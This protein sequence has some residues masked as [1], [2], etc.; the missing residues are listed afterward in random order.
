MIGLVYGTRPEYIK[1]TPL[2]KELNLLEVEYL[3][4]QVCQH[5]TLIDSCSYD[6]TIP[7]KPLTSN[8]L[9]DIVASVG[10]YSFPPEV[11]HL[12]VQ[13][14]TTTA[15][16]AALNAF[17]N[18]IP[19]IHLEAGLRTDD[20]ANPYPEEI[21]RRLISTIATVHYC[22]TELNKINL[23]REGYIRDDILVTGNT[24]IDNIKDLKVSRT[25]E[26][27]VTLHRREKW[28]EM[29]SWY[30]IIDRLAQDWPSYSFVF[31]MHPSPEV[32]R[33][34]DFLKHVKV[35]EP[36]DYTEMQQRLASCALVIT[37]SGGIQEECS[38]LKKWCMVCRKKTERPCR[39]GVIC[40]HPHALLANFPR[41]INRS[42]RELKDNTI[43]GDG[44][45]GK[46][47][48]EDLL[49]RV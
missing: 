46:R 1:L 23:I 44:N 34:K 41:Y 8:R 36:L 38:F 18:N 45:A 32:R 19:V 13:G 6:H 22:P 48:V 15:M 33:H 24:G 43:F 3:L 30:K 47:I 27:I 31:P 2:L 49:R 16:A 42:D 5:T 25:N 28:E 29:D 37:D 40:D 10:E 7:V 35:I 4:F 26:I 17:N 39:S 12:L 14:D 21:N 20:K 11:S 9:N